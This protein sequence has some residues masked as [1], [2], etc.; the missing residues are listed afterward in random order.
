MNID[1][2]RG[3][4]YSRQ[5]FVA[6][7]RC[8]RR[9]F[10]ASTNNVSTV[11][12]GS[13]KVYETSKCALSLIIIYIGNII[14]VLSQE[15]IGKIADLKS[16][17]KRQNAYLIK[18][19]LPVT[20][21]E[22]QQCYEQLALEERSIILSLVPTFAE[23]YEPIEAKHVLPKPFTQFY[24]A[25]FVGKPRESILGECERV[26]MEYLSAF[27]IKHIKS[28]EIVTRGQSSKAIWLT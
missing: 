15:A 4:L 14:I 28:V 10:Y 6:C 13:S 21:K 12:L 16:I 5:C 27:T 2:S 18:S 19:I 8:H 7:C 1:Q 23:K 22:V 26:L 9:N 17:K 3:S 24:N 20:P 11:F 25:T